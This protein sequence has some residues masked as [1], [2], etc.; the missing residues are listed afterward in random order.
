[1]DKY[2]KEKYVITSK[3]SAVV[4]PKEIRISNFGSLGMYEVDTGYFYV[5]EFRIKE[6]LK[7]EE[8][9]LLKEKG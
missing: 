8:I 3:Y 4:K 6:L 1:M 2:E 7:S 5:P 9:E